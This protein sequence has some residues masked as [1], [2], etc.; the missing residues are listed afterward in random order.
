M[1]DE[2]EI[3]IVC[4]KITH[5]DLQ[6]L[7]SSDT[8]KAHLKGFA[9][10]LPTNM[11]VRDEINSIVMNYDVI[12]W[13]GDKY[14][15]DSFTTYLLDYLSNR[16]NQ[17]KLPN[18]IGFVHEDNES[19][20]LISWN[21]LILKLPQSVQ[22]SIETIKIFYYLISSEDFDSN[23][24]YDKFGFYNLELT[25]CNHIIAIGGGCVVHKEYINTLELCKANESRT[26]NWT[27]FPI[28]RTD[29]DKPDEE[30]ECFWSSVSHYHNHTKILNFQIKLMS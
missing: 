28:T 26:I 30:H 21:S 18:T 11:N 4:E 7:L 3:P 20:F 25:K 23:G 16:L 24:D 22:R 15:E 6:Q 10:G 13:D 2:I 1:S 8:S 5:S 29:P 19:D 17:E 9:K 14:K 12:F 27:I